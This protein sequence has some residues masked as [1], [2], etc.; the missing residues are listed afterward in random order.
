MLL[1]IPPCAEGEI[2]PLL[3][4]CAPMA[5]ALF[6]QRKDAIFAHIPVGTELVDEHGRA[7]FKV[8]GA[9]TM[10]AAPHA[11]SGPLLMA[12]HTDSGSNER[13]S[14]RREG[15][16][17]AVVTLSDKGAAGLRED[18]SGPLAMQM[19]C[20][21]LPVCFSQNFLIP[22]NIHILRTLVADLA[23]TQQYD[24]ILTT[25][26]TGLAPR[27]LTPEAL[28]PLLE[29]RLPGFEQAMMQVSLAKTPH[30]MISRAVAGTVGRALVISLPGSNRAVA[31]NLAAVLPACAHAIEKIHDNP[32]DC[33]VDA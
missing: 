20:D 7:R 32:S 30:A 5:A 14:L 28:L 23:L 9:V 10:P 13:F 24:L 19:A 1:T 15:V 2:L 31:E 17:V 25:G 27:D 3:P 8:C 18:K 16:A 11:V 21:Q 26:G 29:R 33:G 22:D 6:V 4:P 12:M